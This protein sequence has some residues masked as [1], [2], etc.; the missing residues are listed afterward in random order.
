ML[1]TPEQIERNGVEVWTSERVDNHVNDDEIRCFEHGN[2]Y[3]FKNM[4]THD[5]SRKYRVLLGRYWLEHW[6]AYLERE[7]ILFSGRRQLFT[8]EMEKD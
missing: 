2:K 3:F 4:R 5:V 1:W 7:T 6:S 8:E